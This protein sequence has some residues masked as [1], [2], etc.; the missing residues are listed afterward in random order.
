MYLTTYNSNHPLG[1]FCMLKTL[2][3]LWFEFQMNVRAILNLNLSEK[4]NLNIKVKECSSETVHIWRYVEKAK[5]CLRWEVAVYLKNCKRKQAAEKCEKKKYFW[6]LK[7]SN[8]SQTHFGFTNIRS[9]MQ[10]F[11]DTAN[12][13]DKWN[14]QFFCFSN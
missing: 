10:R 14:T 5:M 8:A 6:Q 13:L 7:K 4:V 11:S 12:S 1:P 2:Y 9:K 3:S